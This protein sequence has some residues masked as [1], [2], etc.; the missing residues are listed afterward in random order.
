[1][2][3]DQLR[4]LCAQF[5]ELQAT[6]DDLEAKLTE[7]NKALDELRLQK[8][9]ELM[10]ELDVRNATFTGLG[11]VQLAS[12]LYASTKA[13]K[14]DEA[15]QWLRDCGYEDMISETYNASSLKA[16]FRRMITDTGTMPPDE[17]FSVTPFIRASLVKA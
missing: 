10:A 7:T 9:P 12:D 11:R 16:L 3:M 15:M 2:S 17:I 1:M 6:K 13:G 8:I 4:S 5:K 14:K